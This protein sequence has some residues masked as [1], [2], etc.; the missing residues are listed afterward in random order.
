MRGKQVFLA[1]VFLFHRLAADRLHFAVLTA[2]CRFKAALGLLYVTCG[3]YFAGSDLAADFGYNSRDVREKLG[4]FV[5][6]YEQAAG[7]GFSLSF[8]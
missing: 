4:H 3:V 1:V 6:R 7:F 5:K 8:F 2:L